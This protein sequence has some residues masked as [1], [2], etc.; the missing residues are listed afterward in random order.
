MTKKV[1]RITIG[2]LLGIAV[3]TTLKILLVGFDIDEQYAFALSYRFIKGDIPLAEMWEPHQTS[4][5]FLAAIMYPYYKLAGTTGI[6]LY[7]RVFSLL[8]HG[9]VMYFLW[10]YLR[11]KVSVIVAVATTVIMFFSLPKIMFLAEFS[12]ILMWFLLIAI[13]AMLKYLGAEDEKQRKMV[14]LIIAG[15]A[16]VLCIAAYPSMILLYIVFLIALIRNKTSVKRLLTEI[17]SF[18]LPA[19]LCGGVVFSFLLSKVGIAGMAEGAKAIMQDGSHSA[20]FTEKLFHHLDSFKT[21]GLFLAIYLILSIPVC[22][23]LRMKNKEES[24]KKIYILS[25]GFVILLGQIVVWIFFNRYPNYPLIEYFVVP[26]VILLFVITQKNR[27]S[28]ELLLL[29]I[30]PVIAFIGICLLSNHPLLVSAPFLAYVIIGAVVLASDCNWFKT[31]RISRALVVFWAGVICFGHIYMI[32]VTGGEHLTCFNK[33]SLIRSGPAIG[34]I[35]DTGTVWNY[36]ELMK[37]VRDNVPGGSKVLYM[38]TY[39]AVYLDGDYEVCSPNVISTPTYNSLMTVY[40]EN[41]NQKR[42]EYIVSENNY[43]ADVER[44]F[45][46]QEYDYVASNDQT[47]IYRRKQSTD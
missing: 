8:I 40:F 18:L 31:K 41:N 23:I 9:G 3:L 30:A 15:V 19:V 11:E 38:G 7:S 42:P 39:N 35:A 24:G 1:E 28:N 12:N 2:I 10:S 6:V 26:V 16:I 44:L 36:S 4:A 34:I 25:L 13:L 29:C 37:L 27:W 17:I 20:A 45:D 47:S 21:I 32:R 22:L 14:F 46:L 5:F 43:L 33:M